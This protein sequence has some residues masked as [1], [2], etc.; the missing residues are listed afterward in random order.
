MPIKF[1][2]G[3]LIR[4]YPTA[5]LKILGE[6]FVQRSFAEL[7]PQRMNHVKTAATLVRQMQLSDHQT[8]SAAT[9]LMPLQNHDMREVQRHLVDIKALSFRPSCLTSF[10]EIIMRP[11]ELQG[12]A[13]LSDGDRPNTDAHGAFARAM[14]S[15]NPGKERRVARII[16]ESMMKVRA[17]Y[18]PQSAERWKLVIEERLGKATFLDLT[19]PSWRASLKRLQFLAARD[20][21]LA[22]KAPLEAPEGWGMATLRIA[23][24]SIST[25][26]IQERQLKLACLSVRM[27]GTQ[28]NLDTGGKLCSLA[29]QWLQSQFG[30]TTNDLIKLVISDPFIVIANTIADAFKPSASIAAAS[31]YPDAVFGWQPVIT[32][33]EFC[34]GHKLPALAIF[35]GNYPDVH[36]LAATA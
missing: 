18:P 30:L 17:N 26:G 5:H 3:L 13:I 11:N 29:N 36:L 7:R 6:G 14:S 15:Q 27:P 10:L 33:A 25:K 23:P 22:A 21:A 16:A 24:H 4:E 19:E 8:M 28:I 12:L 34:M 32:A 20:L 35:T 9:V 31:I 2:E 1:N